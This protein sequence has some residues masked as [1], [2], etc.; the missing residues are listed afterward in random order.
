MRSCTTRSTSSCH[1]DLSIFCGLVFFNSILELFLLV[2]QGVVPFDSIKNLQLDERS[3]EDREDKLA[4]VLEL[5]HVVL[6][7]G[8]FV[9]LLPG[10]SVPSEKQKSSGTGEN[11]AC[12]S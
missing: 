12:P 10:L 5:L 7:F 9:E 8:L 1:W 4:V 2:M 11:G 3:F 6:V